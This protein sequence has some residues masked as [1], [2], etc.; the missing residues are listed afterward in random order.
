[1]S[2]TSCSKHAVPSD[3]CLAC[4]ELRLRTLNT[5]TSS[6]IKFRNNGE[7]KLQSITVDGVVFVPQRQE[8]GN[9]LPTEDS[10][11]PQSDLEAQFRDYLLTTY[12]EYK[13][14]CYKS[15]KYKVMPTEPTFDGFISYL[16]GQL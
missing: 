12:T 6:T 13:N 9:D 3:S 1:M 10:T 11:P 7:K 14:T 5:Y 4:T 15:P 8:Q 16:R 2:K